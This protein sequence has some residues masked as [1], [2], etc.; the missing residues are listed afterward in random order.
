M[1]PGSLTLGVLGVLPLISIALKTYS[2]VRTTFTTYRHY[3]RAMKRL[4]SKVGAEKQLFVNHTE[5]LVKIA[6][7]EED[8]V[9]AM[10]KNEADS[11]W[12][13]QE[14]ENRIR[15]RL[16][17]NYKACR[18]VFEEIISTLSEIESEMK[19]MSSDLRVRKLEVRSYKISLYQP[20]I[21]ETH[22]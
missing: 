5:M 10:V 13:D 19:L 8:I 16:S 21:L 9:L 12:R 11:R 3:S 4:S 2:N 6:V 18:D 15:Q 7:K 1:D 22:I 20:T 17:D 14:T